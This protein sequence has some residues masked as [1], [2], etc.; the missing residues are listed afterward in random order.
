MLFTTR[1]VVQP[2]CGCSIKRCVMLQHTRFSLLLYKH[3]T[4]RT[5]L[6]KQNTSTTTC[7]C[8]C[9]LLLLLMVC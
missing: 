1:R 7:C 5:A 8:C 2:W 3:T 6:H 9:H 4:W